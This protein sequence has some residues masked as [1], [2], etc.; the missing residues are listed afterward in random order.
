MN[1]YMTGKLLG[2]P[3]YENFVSKL[4][5]MIHNVGDFEYWQF[6]EHPSK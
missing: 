5:Q 2:V 1:S 6:F 3:G 4:S